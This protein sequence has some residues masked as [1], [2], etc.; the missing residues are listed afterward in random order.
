[1]LTS[2]EKI[3]K[4]CMAPCN[5]RCTNFNCVSLEGHGTQERENILWVLGEARGNQSLAAQMLGI[6]RV[7]LWRKLKR[8]GE[9][10]D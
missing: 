4:Y 9:A 10:E 1:M 3:E 5:A 7:S 6:D 8:Y 2:R